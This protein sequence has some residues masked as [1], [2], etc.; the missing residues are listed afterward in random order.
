MVQ[1]DGQGQWHWHSQRTSKKNFRIISEASWR[2]R[3]SGNRRRPYNGRKGNSS[4]RRFRGCGIGGLQGEH[5][6]DNTSEK[7]G[8]GKG[9][10]IHC[11]QHSSQISYRS[12]SKD[13]GC[14]ERTWTPFLAS[15]CLHR[16]RLQ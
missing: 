5:F 9:Q 12:G 16:R 10:T 1:S 6:L 14:I 8:T 4:V 7:T 13:R 2:L 11:S 3:I 15:L